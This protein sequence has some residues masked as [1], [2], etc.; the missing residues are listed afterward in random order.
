MRIV[1][2]GCDDFAAVNLKRLLDDGHQLAALVTQPDKPKGRGMHTAFSPTKELAVSRAIEVLQ[3]QDLK[4][5]A[6]IEQLKRYGADVFVVVA[7]GKFLPEVILQIPKYFCVNVHPSLLPRYRGAAPIN[8]AVINGDAET[9][10]TLI[11]VNAS[12]DGGDIL[13]QEKYPLPP[14][15]TS[16][17]LRERLAVFGAQML[18]RTLPGIPS[19]KFELLTQDSAFATRAPKLHKELGAIQWTDTARRIHDLVRGT[20]PW[21]GAYTFLRGSMLKILQAEA[22]DIAVSGR[23]PGE[24]V[25]LHKDGFYVQAG[26]GPVLI[27]RVHPAGGRAMDARSFLAGHKL[28]VGERLGT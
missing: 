14:D 21:P 3:P 2:F 13:A 22:G 6:I 9:G 26:D 28:A 18:S 11:R 5:P 16:A 24:I 17:V 25:E 8:W 19:G 4:A 23:G 12:M 10:V 1:F 7:Y 27:K 20:Q 15:I